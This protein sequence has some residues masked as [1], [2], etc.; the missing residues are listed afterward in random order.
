MNP[1]KAI[2]VKL[3]EMI[4]TCNGGFDIEKAREELYEEVDEFISV[5]MIDTGKG[6]EI[7]D[8]VIS[9]APW[10]DWLDNRRRQLEMQADPH[11][12][13]GVNRADFH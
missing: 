4:D 1:S 5:P 6:L 7:V 10:E 12:Y 9:E 2:E 8:T 11:K 13:H 3:Q